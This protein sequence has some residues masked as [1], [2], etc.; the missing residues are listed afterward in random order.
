M[1]PEAIMY[2]IPLGGMALSALFL[3]GAYKLATR[4]LDA[5]QRRLGGASS[6]EL[7]HLREEV[8]GL[9]GLR[10]RVAELEERVDFAER[11]LAQ[12]PERDRLAPGA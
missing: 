10:D 1:N 2:F 6:G 3:V 7:D 5:R 8:A 4:W 9:T 12:R 11:L